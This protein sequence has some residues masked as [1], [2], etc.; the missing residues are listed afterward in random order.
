M[1]EDELAAFRKRWKQELTG[2]KEEQ[3]LVCAP[4]PSWDVPGHTGQ[5]DREKNRYFEEVKNLDKARSP[6]K[7][8]EGGCSEDEGCVGGG[9]GGGKAA[10]EPEDQPEYVSIA[11]SLLDGRTSPLLDRIQE[12]RTRRKRQYHNTTNVCSASLQLQQPQRKVRKD[13][14]LLDQLIQDLV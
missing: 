10:A 1:A 2:K 12:E 8:E 5:R 13:K 11:R 9:R 7:P 6:S 4:S 14:E 3:P